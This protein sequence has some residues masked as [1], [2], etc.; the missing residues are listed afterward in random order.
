MFQE[1]LPKTHAMTC[2][3]FVHIDK[4]PYVFKVVGLKT[5]IGG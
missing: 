1:L 5:N 2:V 3:S 4:L